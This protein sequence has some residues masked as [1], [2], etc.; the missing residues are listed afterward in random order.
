VLLVKPMHKALITTA[1]TAKTIK[2]LK[3]GHNKIV[4][5]FYSRSKKA[6]LAFNIIPGLY[7]LKYNDQNL[8]NKQAQ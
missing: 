1:T 5:Y 7:D 3:A 8:L 6:I 2:R 4:S